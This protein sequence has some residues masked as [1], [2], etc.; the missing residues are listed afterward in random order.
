MI[1]INTKNKFMKKNNLLLSKK[2][3]SII[4]T[5]FLLVQPFSS[6]ASIQVISSG[7]SYDDSA[8]DTGESFPGEY[9][10]STSDYE[11]YYSSEDDSSDDYV[12][13][14]NSIDDSSSDYD[15]YFNEPDEDDDYSLHYE[16][17]ESTSDYEWY[18]NDS[19][20]DSSSNSGWY[21]ESDDDPYND[22]NGDSS[23]DYNWYY[24]SDDD[25]YN[26]NQDLTSNYV[27]TND[28]DC[29][30]ECGYVGKKEYSGNS[31]RICGDYD[32]DC[33]L[34]WSSWHTSNPDPCD[35][36][37][38]KKCYNNDVY[39]YDSCGER[40]EKYKEC[41]SDSW[42]D[43]YRCSGDIVQRE[44]IERGCS[45]G[46]CYEKEVW[47]DYQDCSDLGKVCQNGQCVVLSPSVDIEANGSDGPIE[48]EYGDSVNLS[49]DSNNVDSCNAFGG[50]IGPISISGSQS[51][52]N[53]YSSKTYTIICSGPGGYTDDSVTVNVIEEYNN[54]PEADAGSDRE[55]YEGESI[56][57]Y[58]Y[59]YDEEDGDDLDYDWD[60]TGG[61]IYDSHDD[62]PTF[63]AP[64]VSS[65]RYYT[66]TLTVEDSNGLTDSDSARILVK[67]EDDEDDNQ[68]PEADAG[69][70]REVY[71]GESITLYGYGYDEEDGDD[72]DY[73]W[74]CTGGYIYDSHD[75]RPTFK[76]P[77]VSSDRYY[78]CTLTVEDSDGLTDSDSARILV[79]DE[80]D[81]DEDVTLEVKKGVKNITRGDD[82]WYESLSAD[83]GDL[84]KFRIRIFSEGDDTADDVKVREYLPD[85]IDFTGD[86][87]VD[88][89]DM[90]EDISEEDIEIGDIDPGDNVVVTFYARVDSKTSFSYGRTDLINKA[91]AFNSEDSD[92]DDCKIMVNRTGVAGASTDVST[93]ITD[94]FF[95]SLVLPLG[96]SFLLVWLFSSKLITLDEWTEDKRK[97]V[98]S[99]QA[100][101]SLESKIAKIKTKDL[102]N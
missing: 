74:D 22:N 49:W 57:L 61:Y 31:Y 17:E 101:R 62:R 75:D 67:D 78:T 51:T 70:D 43:N 14:Y 54:P 4:L 27:S 79:K 63:K 15:W 82:T 50:W 32:S 5:G 3:F 94:S 55:V 10:E 96:L 80:D 18:Y 90:D 16:S 81:E 64:S 26:D 37:E 34:E 35:S 1:K 13:D 77:S 83:P 45:C 92:E 69:S 12:W 58:G 8:W 23:S 88:E 30:D 41:G 36:H 39:W 52:G 65:D 102:R 99:F 85:E 56:T 2:V 76:A 20:D 59:G 84:L 9:E 60:C 46:S 72:L 66:C 6:L 21:Y 42:T 48:I 7:P 38:D 29:W 53:L 97:R 24:E 33:C 11:W 47:E 93:G 89:E 86:L 100:K 25:S 91:R 44:K 40:E 95:G 28:N 68:R 71:E 98:R 19:D 87:E 73:D